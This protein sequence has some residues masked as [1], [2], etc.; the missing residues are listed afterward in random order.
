MVQSYFEKKRFL[1][2]IQDLLFHRDIFTCYLSR[3]RSTIGKT[4]IRFPKLAALIV[5]DSVRRCIADNL[6]KINNYFFLIIKIYKFFC[7]KL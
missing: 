7:V 4:I 5:V 1:A 6:W 3:T 2:T